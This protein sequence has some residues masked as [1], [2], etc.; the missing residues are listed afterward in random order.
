MK[1]T[2]QLELARLTNRFLAHAT[3]IATSVAK[4]LVATMK[5]VK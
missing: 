2:A 3:I 5:A 1:A 4:A